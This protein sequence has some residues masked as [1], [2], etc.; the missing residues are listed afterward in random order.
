MQ[1][2]QQ[3]IN[4]MSAL[5]RKS[6]FANPQAQMYSIQQPMQQTNLNRNPYNNSMTQNGPTGSLGQFMMGSGHGM[7]MNM[8]L[9]G[10]IHSTATGSMAQPGFV[11]G[12]GPSAAPS[13]QRMHATASNQ[14]ARVQE[15]PALPA[16][17]AQPD[18]HL[19]LSTLQCFLRYQ[20]EAFR[21]HEDDILT[22]TRG[23]N[24]PIAIGQ[25]GIRCKF[26]AHLPVA[27]RQKGSTYFPASRN[28]IYQAAQNMV[29]L[30]LSVI[31]SSIPYSCLTP[32]YFFFKKSAAHMCSG[33]CTEMPMIVKQQLAIFAATKAPSSGAGRPYWAHSAANLGLVDTEDGIRHVHD[34][35]ARQQNAAAAVTETTTRS[36]NESEAKT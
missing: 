31:V 8:A 16:I 11:M 20:I 29:R 22:H 36:G 9:P 32:T 10:G 34:V 30:Q 7:G 13:Q 1:Q 17:L 21:A 26:C 3:Q 4:F 33:I 15:N 12:A 18:D 23:R 2:Q 27:R 14:H 24:K 25:V 28:G 6:N 5:N 35:R 19:K